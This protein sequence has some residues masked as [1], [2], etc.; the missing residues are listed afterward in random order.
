[1]FNHVRG[2]HPLK[3]RSRSH[4]VGKRA[5]TIR[6][7]QDKIDLRDPVCAHVLVVRIVRPELVSREY[8]DVLNVRHIVR[9][10]WLIKRADLQAA[11]PVLK[12]KILK[13]CSRRIESEVIVMD[14]SI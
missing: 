3:W 8:V 6:P 4:H 11:P 2:D 12:S 1:V 13:T 5:H 14:A 7:A 9:K 10:E